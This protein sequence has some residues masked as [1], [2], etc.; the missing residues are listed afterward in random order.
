MTKC[1]INTKVGKV[2]KLAIALCVNSLSF[3]HEQT[4]QSFFANTEIVKSCGL[5]CCW[6]CCLKRNLTR[7][8]QSSLRLN[9]LEVKSPSKKL[10]FVTKKVYF[11]RK[12]KCNL[13]FSQ[14]LSFF[15][16]QNLSLLSQCF[17]TKRTDVAFRL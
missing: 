12:L 3:S 1:C 13:K 8:K 11:M 5:G 10:T 2:S 14:R 15:N 6:S 4:N 17:E 7:V 9:R 16:S